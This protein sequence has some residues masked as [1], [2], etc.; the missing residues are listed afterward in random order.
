MSRFIDFVIGVFIGSIAAFVLS[1]LAGCVTAAPVVEC[2]LMIEGI[3][4]ESESVVAADLGFG[5][6]LEAESADGSTSSYLF[7]APGTDATKMLKANSG[8][9]LF[10]TCSVNDGVQVH[11]VSVLVIHTPAPKAI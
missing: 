11:A 8:A 10:G 5:F 3:Q 2:A 1:A 7:L 9:A 4:T 6:A